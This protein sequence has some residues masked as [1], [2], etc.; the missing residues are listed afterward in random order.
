MNAL[1]VAGLLSLLLPAPPPPHFAMPQWAEGKSRPLVLTKSGNYDCTGRIRKLGTIPPVVKEYGRPALHIMADGVEMRHFAW[2]GSMEG[3]HVDSCPFNAHG[4]RLRHKA[5]R[6]TLDGLH[7]DDV[8]E[9]A[10][11]I[12]PRARVTIR[13]SRLRGNFRI[14]KGEGCNPGLDKLV[15]IDGAEVLFEDCEFHNGFTAIRGKANSRVVVRRCRFVNCAN[16]VL[17]DGN[18]NPRPG[19]AYDNGQAG[20]CSIVVEDCEFWDCRTAIR[21]GPLCTVEMRRV[22]VHD[23]WHT[24]RK[25]GGIIIQR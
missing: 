2:R 9:D 13:N 20:P 23:T 1:L 7:C 12:G 22:K 21:A 18:P 10:V 6:V 19:Q 5:I 11:S 17:G 16:G 3:V 4:M 14:T 8:G 25:E 15:Q 24:A